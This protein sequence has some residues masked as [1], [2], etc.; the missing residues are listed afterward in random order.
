LEPVEFRTRSLRGG[1]TMTKG[2]TI[3][4]QWNS[5][6]VARVVGRSARS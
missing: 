3:G 6:V 2:I 1:V 4:V 5:G